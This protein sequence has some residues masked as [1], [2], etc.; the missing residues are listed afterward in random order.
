MLVNPLGRLAPTT[1]ATKKIIRAVVVR[2]QTGV[3]VFGVEPTNDKPLNAGHNCERKP[4]T[5]SEKQLRVNRLSVYRKQL[6]TKS[7][8]TN[9][10]HH[11]CL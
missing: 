5:S 8:T 10:E 6:K 3:D 11:F 2:C 9:T 1:T 7:K 4:L